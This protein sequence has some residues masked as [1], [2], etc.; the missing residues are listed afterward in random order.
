[1]SL[2]KDL[3]NNLI[4]ITSSSAIACFPYIGKN[5]K[6]L[7][8][9]AA[10]DI[11]RDKLN[12]LNI[13]GEV[14]IGEG[15]LDEA[16]MLYIGE[17]LGKAD[18]PKIDIAVDP[19]EGTN[20]VAKNLPGSMSVL[21]VSNKG[22]L[23]NAPETYMDKIAVG[24]HI[25]RDVI[26][27]DFTVEK[28]IRNYSDATNKKISDIRVCILDRPRHKK[29]I[30]E[31]NRLKVNI[32]L[33]TDG[34]VS[35]ALLVSDKKFKVDIFMGIG[36]GP[37]GVIAAAALSTLNCHFQGRFLFETDNDKHRAT[38][39]GINNLN[40]KYEINEIIKGES[41]FCATGITQGELVEGVSQKKDKLITETIFTY[42]KSILESV[43]KEFSHT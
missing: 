40:K 30:N 21:A 13:N 43:K 28:N 42:K 16:P 11:M 36:G 17:K 26:D 29:I 35:G 24:S 37:E 14:V 39:M 3:L 38:K 41:I 22:D 10:T 1:M 31:L 34:D 20:F 27:L 9:K 15:E 6:I 18:E 4:D 8:D 19:V 23:F 5:E 25:P 32:K 12:K 2:T 7:A 33:I